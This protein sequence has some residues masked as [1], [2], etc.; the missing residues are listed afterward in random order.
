M[1][2]QNLIPVQFSI[3]ETSDPTLTIDGDNNVEIYIGQGVE[4]NCTFDRGGPPITEA[5]LRNSQ[6]QLF[7]DSERN[8]RL[9]ANDEDA[10]I[11]EFRD[12]DMAAGT[13]IINITVNAGVPARTLYGYLVVE[14]GT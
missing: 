7:T 14:Q 2:E 6:L 11:H 12:I 8:D 9:G 3:V 5:Q 13:A 1:P 4:F 10:F